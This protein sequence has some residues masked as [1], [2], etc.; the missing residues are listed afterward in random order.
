M[1]R[2]ENR[3]LVAFFREIPRA[4]KA[5]RPRADDGNAL[6]VCRDFRL[7]DRFAFFER[8]VGDE[9]LEAA[10]ADGLALLAEDAVFLALVFLRAD[11]AADGRQRVRFLDF[12]D[13]AV[14]VALFDLRDEFRDVDGHGAAFAALRHFA[15][16]AAFCLRDRRLLVVAERDLVEIV[17]ADARVLHR[18]R[19]FFE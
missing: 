3:N 9:T 6:R 4:G 16:Q 14:I 12:R 8:T 15:M 13:S 10:D 7:R 5:G 2:F 19:M 18:H 17:R 1:E 11:A